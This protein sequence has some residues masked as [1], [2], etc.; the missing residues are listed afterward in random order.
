[1]QDTCFVLIFFFS[2]G[3]NIFFHSADAHF[4]MMHVVAQ[5]H[6]WGRPV[7]RAG[8]QMTEEAMNERGNENEAKHQYWHFTI[9]INQNVMLGRAFFAPLP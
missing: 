5:M 7:S 6:T 8:C 4:Q 2:G 3:E 1:M 9:C